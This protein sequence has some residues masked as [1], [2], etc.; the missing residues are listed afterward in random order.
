[1]I[2][3]LLFLFLCLAPILGDAGSEYISFQYELEPERGQFHR[4]MHNVVIP[5]EISD[6]VRW[7]VYVNYCDQ[8][9]GQKFLGEYALMQDTFVFAMKHQFCADSLWNFNFFFSGC[10]WPRNASMYDYR[11]GGAFYNH[12]TRKFYALH[13]SGRL[14]F[15]AELDRIRLRLTKRE[16]QQHYARVIWEESD[17]NFREFITNSCENLNSWFR[18]EAMRRGYLRKDYF[19]YGQ[20][21]ISWLENS[22][23]R[24]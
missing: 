10:R 16:G 18:L 2:R 14:F 17:A 22:N 7:M 24:F 15:V 5:T 1:M 23:N 6:S 3:V 4:E 19:Y 20:E 12:L 9:D 21:I 8:F 11:T 13:I